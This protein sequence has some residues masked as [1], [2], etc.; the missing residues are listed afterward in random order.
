[1]SGFKVDE[2]NMIK[3]YIGICGSIRPNSY[4]QAILNYIRSNDEFLGDVNA[5]DIGALPHYSQDTEENALPETVLSARKK[6]SVSKGVIIVTPEYNHGIPGVLKNALDWF[7]RPIFES[8]IQE[9]PVFFLTHSPGALG[10]VRAQYQIRETLV[11]LNCRLS[12]TP[13]IAITHIRNKVTDGKL[14]DE[15]TKKILTENLQKFKIFSTE[16]LQ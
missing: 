9:K 2:S 16:R 5:I 3:N 14:T 6:I 7:S 8:C 12:P 13:E 11:T 10:G 15:A 4:S 1:M